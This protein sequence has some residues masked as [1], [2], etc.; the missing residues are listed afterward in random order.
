MPPEVY[1]QLKDW[2]NGADR[3]VIAGIGNP[4]RSD[5]YVGTKIV[6][7]LQNKLSGNVQ[8]IECET[9]PESFILEI[10]EFKPSHVLLIDAALLELTP[11]EA[12][13]VFPEQVAGF[14]AFSSHVLPLRVFSDYLKET[15]GAKI[16]MLLIQPKNI[17]FG[18]GLSAELA[19]TS[20]QVEG[21]LTELLSPL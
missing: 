17:E 9:V 7:Q 16:A 10:E 4:I 21:W 13:L 11:G 15:T 14:S 8:L 19:T 2:L 20:K 6:Q 5:D 3:V 18:E 1:R 12:R